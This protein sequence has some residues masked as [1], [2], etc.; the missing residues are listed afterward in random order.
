[1]NDP[2]RG[3]PPPVV[4]ACPAR[5]RAAEA[6]AHRLG[7][8]LVATLPAAPGRLA[9]VLTETRLQ[10]QLTGRDAPGAVYAEFVHGRTGARGR[11]GVQ[12]AEALARAAGAR[13]GHRPVVIDATAGLGRDAFV[14]AARGCA[15][16]LIER[17]PVVDALL[18]DGLARALDDPDAAAVAARMQRV[19]GDARRLLARRGADVVLV[20]PM[21]PPRR[22][23]AA[24]RKEMRVLRALVGPDGDSDGLLQAALAAARER[25]VVKR[26]A[27]A[28]A[29]PGPAPTG[30]VAGRST[31]FDIY[32]G[33]AT[34]ATLG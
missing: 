3:Q 2:A 7:S 22:K 4:C 21:H 1:M 19:H 14:L 24:V 8:E 31:R 28:E 23:S 26:P 6:L 10:L 12:G 29:L 17:H 27:G 25:V 20:D 15:V 16:T 13:R 32:A 18:A 33:R 11:A 30:A 5:R 34:A 9:L